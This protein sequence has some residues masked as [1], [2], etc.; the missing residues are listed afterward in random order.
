MVSTA[1]LGGGA[2][3]SAWNLFNTYRGLGHSIQL[4]VGTRRTNDPDVVV[5]P[6]DAGR[7]PWA[8]YWIKADKFLQRFEGRVRGIT[9]SRNLCGWIGEPR[10]AL[11]R[12]RGYEDFEFPGTRQLLEFSRL[13]DV[14]HCFN[15]HTS[16]FDLRILPQLSQQRPVL[17]DL[18]DA[19][20]LSGH[21][22]HSFDCDRWKT[23]CGQ[24]PDL[25]IYPEIQRD[26][27]EFNWRRKR[28]IFSRSRLYVAT[29][30]Q[31]L[32]KKVRESMLAPGIVESRVIPTGVDLSIFR[33]SDKAS[34]RARLNI[35]GSANVF[36]FA[37]NGIRQNRWKDYKTMS[38]A[39]RLLAER[40]RRRPLLFIAL[41]EDAPEET[42]GAARIRFI[43]HIKNAKDVA[44]YY[45]A[46]DVYMHAATADTFPRAVLEALASGTP[47]VATGVGGIPEQV[48]SLWDSGS[49]GDTKATGVV[50]P[51]GDCQ[52]M[53]AAMQKLVG[54]EGL[55]RTLSQNAVLDAGDR[56]DLLKQANRYLDWYQDLTQSQTR[57][58]FS[59]A[60]SHLTQ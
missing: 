56:F 10:R 33:P 26:G 17:L 3:I 43:P 31:W 53:A 58:G 47:V 60:T 27:T 20:L 1:D 21:C 51:S 22:A 54:D 7:N 28:E 46:S 24:C 18:R 36:L 40:E 39:V 15:L 4:T 37:A 57:T 38:A 45:Q 55:T 14:V 19:W 25:S 32:M 9:R 44:A 13:A 23:G 29:P 16:Y 35:P 6:R 41:G 52:A 50:V 42:I 2:E 12:A 11:G 5:I 34:V 8:R 49:F 48:K 30:S 59:Y